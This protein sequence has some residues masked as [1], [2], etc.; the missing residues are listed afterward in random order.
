MQFVP[1]KTVE[2]QAVLMIH[3][4]RQ[5]LV[6]QRTRLGNAIRAHLAEMGIVAVQSL[7]R[8]RPGASAG[9]RRWP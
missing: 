7:P 2:S 1:L 3:R 6:E 4:A 8:R 9:W 5:L